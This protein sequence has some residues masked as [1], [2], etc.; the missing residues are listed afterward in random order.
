[1]L[2]TFLHVCEFML[3]ADGSVIL[4]DEFENSLGVNCIKELT[5]GISS[6]KRRLQFIL[7]SHHP[8]IINVINFFHWK[9]DTRKANKVYVKDATRFI[10]GKSKHEAF[11]QLINLPEYQEEV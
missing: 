11:L 10:T 3:C 7:T 8:Y 6:N 9:I 5:S 1:M 4:V 2:R